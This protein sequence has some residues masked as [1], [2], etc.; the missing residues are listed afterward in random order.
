MAEPQIRYES[1]QT[2]H[3]FEAMTTED[4]RKFSADFFPWSDA[5]G[6]PLIIAPYGLL[7][8]GTINPVGGSDDAV[9]VTALTASMAGVSSSDADGVVAVGAEAEVAVARGETTNTHRITSITVNSSGEIAAVDGTAGE[10]FTEDRGEAGGPPYIPV[11]SIEIGQVRLT[12]TTSAPVEASEIFAVPGLHVERA[13]F[14]VWQTDF[15]RGEITFADALP[16]IHTG[17]VSKQVWV[18]GSTPLFAPIPNTSDW[19]PAESTFSITSTE[20]YDG[21]VGSASRSLNQATFTAVMR[22]G[23]SDAVLAKK[24]QNIWFEFRPDRD[25]TIP[26]QL[27]QGIFGVSRTFP[28]GGG[29]FTAS[30]TVTP[31]NESVDIKE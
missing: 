8:G 18:R 20:T 21:P 16:A 26:R 2:A 10:A 5:D 3:P 22:D 27:T 24:G 15:A 6:A 19:V 30:C 31:R 12:S 25:K 4:R 9:S 28:A 13:D 11:G 7:T 14:P 17:D 1:G 29:N 23:I